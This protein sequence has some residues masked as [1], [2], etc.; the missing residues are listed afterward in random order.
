M[1]R[2]SLE[3]AGDWPLIITNSSWATQVLR[4]RG[5]NNLH[6]CPP[7]VDLERFYPAPRTGL[8]RD[9]FVVFSGG[10]LEY[11]QGQDIL[12]GAFRIFHQRHPEALLV[13]GWS[14]MA[15]HGSDDLLR[16]PYLDGVPER[17]NGIV[18]LTPWL[19]RNGIAAQALLDLSLVA[20][21]QLPDILR[22]SDLAVFPSRC[23][24]G[25]Q[26]PALQAMACGVPTVVAANTGYLDLLGEHVYMLQSQGELRGQSGAGGQDDWG[27][28][29]MDELLELMERAY[30]RRTEAMAKGQAGAQFM[31]NRGCDSHARQLLTAI[32]RVVGGA[33]LA[34]TEVQDDYSWGLCLHRAGRLGEAERAYDE[35]L[36]RQ[37][38]HI[39]AR[40]DRGNARRDL[41]DAQGAE[42]DFRTLLAAHPGNPRVLHSLGNLL[43]RDGRVDE[44]ANCLQQALR[45]MQSAALHWDLA[46]TL[47]LQGRYREAWPHF[48]HRHE[49]LGLRSAAP[50]KPRWDGQPLLDSTLLVLDE[51]GLGDTLQFLRFVSH[52][53]KGPGGRVIFAGKPATLAVARRI[54]PAVD[55]YAWDQPLP[56]SQ[57]WIPLMSLPMRLGMQ[58]PQ[59]IPAPCSEPL[60]DPAHVAHWRALVRG[61]DVQPVVALCWRGNP[62]FSGDSLRSPGLA[63]LRPILEVEGVRFVSLQVGPGRSELGELGLAEQICD[64]G[65]AIEAAGAQVLDTLA[66]LQSCDFVISSCTSVL[67][68]AGLLGRPGRALLCHRPD[69]R[70]MLTRMD[71]PWYPSL[72]LIRQ[73][74]TGDWSAVAWEAATQLRAWRDGQEIRLDDVAHRP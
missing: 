62:E 21:S 19:L 70:W 50:E 66:V 17:V 16:S 38:E 46:F 32:D 43:R 72:R 7:G 29:S 22:E 40:A 67:H 44:A 25:A 73:D 57:V 49:A 12:L 59:D 27:E 20:D 53:P 37:P 8:F 26:W 60:V 4:G 48:E 52:I 36:R 64:V 5:L 28:S 45:G 55:V 23:E 39:G 3:R 31:A 71:T 14:R 51:Q 69:W 10:Q 41:G 33:A 34:S 35:V 2:E 47:L 58:R 54:L 30:V 11:R 13:C 74:R 1:S 9:R 6:C 18:Q 61:S 63:A 24:G 68:M 15:A 65:A 56:R 42:A